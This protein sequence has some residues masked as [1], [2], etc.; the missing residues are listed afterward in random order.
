MG[1]EPID[2]VGIKETC[3]NIKDQSSCTANSNCEWGSTINF[4][5]L[6][7]SIINPIKY[8][9][10]ATDLSINFTDLKVPPITPTCKYKGTGDP[11]FINCDLIIPFIKGELS[12][13]NS[14]IQTDLQQ[15]LQSQSKP[16]KGG[17]ESPDSYISSQIL[18]LLNTEF[19]KIN[20]IKPNMKIVEDDIKL[21]TN[22]LSSGSNA[23]SC[24]SQTIL[25]GMNCDQYI[26]KKLLPPAANNCQYMQQ[27]MGANCIGCGCG[28][29][30]IPNPSEPDDCPAQSILNGMNCDQYIGE[31]LLPSAANN[32]QYLQQ[33]M[34]ADCAG[35]TCG[36][37]PAPKPTPS[38]G[39]PPVQD[40]DNIPKNPI[41][42]IPTSC[43]IPSIVESFF[44]EFEPI[45]VDI[46]NSEVQTQMLDNFPMTVDLSTEPGIKIQ[47]VVCSNWLYPK[48]LSINNVPSDCGPAVAAGKGCGGIAGP[49]QITLDNTSLKIGDITWI[50][51]TDVPFTLSLTATLHPINIDATMIL[52]VRRV[53]EMP[54]PVQANCIGEC[55]DPDEAPDGCCGDGGC[56]AY[57]FLGHDQTA[58]TAPYISAS[59]PITVSGTFK[60]K[61]QTDLN[62]LGAC[63]S[64]DSLDLSLKPVFSV[65]KGQ[66]AFKVS[67]C[68][69]V[70]VAAAAWVFDYV[71]AKKM[72]WWQNLITN[73][74]AG[75]HPLLTGEKIL[76]SL[77]SALGSFKC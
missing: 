60:L 5:K 68:D 37:K 50:P 61:N 55:L 45:F 20:T 58:R 3:S 38:P 10:K 49:A 56:C 22:P 36:G 39:P 42:P 11:G 57:V 32:C 14:E 27:Y 53:Q 21:N 71:I 44:S 67:D 52:D 6:E 1:D 33:Y 25:N 9:L 72:S 62:N 47:E 63:V 41:T 65:T 34:K 76:P 70:F 26:E 46:L 31:K 29:K 16:V 59:I 51:V 17:K 40:C 2:I 24:T 13:Y 54:G 23:A 43:N 28:G 48:T 19:Q 18:T 69:S 66:F 30:P 8:C 73:I 74:V 12:K 4:E 15:F 7:K 77:E 75:S 35:C 64:I